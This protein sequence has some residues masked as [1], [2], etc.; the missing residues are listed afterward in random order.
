MNGA[1]DRI[2][3]GKK[4]PLDS[5]KENPYGKLFPYHQGSTQ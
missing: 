4:S 3:G 1:I 2:A 5:W